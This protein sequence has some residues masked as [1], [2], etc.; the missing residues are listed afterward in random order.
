MSN[1]IKSIDIKSFRGI[2]S[3]KLDDIQQINILTG[4]NNSGKTSVLEI[5]ENFESP[6]YVGGWRPLLRRDSRIPSTWGI[7]FYDGFYNLFDIDSEN[8]IVEYRIS[9][10]SEMVTVSLSAK[11]V[12]EELTEEEYNN[13]IGMSY[14]YSGDDKDMDNSILYPVKKMELEVRINGAVSDTSEIYEGQRVLKLSKIGILK[15]YERKKVVYISPIRHAEGS[16][17]LSE[18][19]N[20][21]DLYEEMLVVLKE[22][23]EDIISINYDN[24][25][26]RSGGRGVYKILSKT[27]KKA[28]PLNVYGDGMKKAVLLMS[29]VVKAKNGVLLLDEF[30]TA[31]HTSAMDRTFKWI[32]ET[33]V[34]LNVQ[35]F[36]T[37]HSKEAID[38]VLKCSPD[39]LD[40]IAV[41]T[42]YKDEL[43]SS[44]RRLSGKKAIEV[45]DDMGLELR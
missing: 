36:M 34:K 12:E 4:D 2:R 27:H 1:F 32:L 41:Y 20:N 19:L 18:I 10:L 43:G 44:V 5:L 24:D 7:S 6:D 17:Y 42:L 28:L 9:T 22:Y 21:P 14:K 33:C 11:T 35:V 40:K 37:S 3:L 8:K 15:E 39:I 25:D 45:Q 13:A 38:K 29:A 16:V 23:D 31:I 26:N 30:E